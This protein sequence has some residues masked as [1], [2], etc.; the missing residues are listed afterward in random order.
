MYIHIRHVCV[1]YYITTASRVDKSRVDI[2]F[3]AESLKS[4]YKLRNK[5]DITSGNI[6]RNTPRRYNINIYIYIYL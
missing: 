5:H 1:A 3:T 4:Y 6:H 2:R